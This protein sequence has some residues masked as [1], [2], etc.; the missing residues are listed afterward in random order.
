MSAYSK[1]SAKSNLKLVKPPNRGGKSPA[2][3]QIR[4]WV[5]APA[6]MPANR[7]KVVVESAAKVTKYSRPIPR[8]NFY[9]GRFGERAT[10][11]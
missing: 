11:F 2:K 8:L 10:R 5:K 7:Y 3:Q 4:R 6:G 1:P 9:G